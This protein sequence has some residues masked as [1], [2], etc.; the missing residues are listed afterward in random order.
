[1]ISADRARRRLVD[2]NDFLGFPPD[3]VAVVTG[4]GGGIGLAIT[5]LLDRVGIKVAAWD[6][7]TSGVLTELEE[8]ARLRGQAVVGFQ[9][10]V[11]DSAQVGDAFTATERRLGPIQFLVNNAGP[12]SKSAVDFDAG[13][14]AALG[15]VASV[16][17]AWL[18]TAGSRNGHV[19]NVSSVAG[20]WL[21]S[22]SSPWYAAAKAGIAGYT[23][24]LAVLRPNG[25]RANAI[26]PSVTVTQRTAPFIDGDAFQRALARNPMGR[27]GLPE[28]MATA[29]VFLLAPASS[30][31][32]GVLLPVDGGAVLVP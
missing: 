27:L 19:V 1:L 31:V 18:R 25:I 15:S 12:S 17:D 9:V 4:A 8:D 24:Q 2:C 11:T 5:R 32:N 16:T 20:N 22:A 21:G 30:Y 29:A 23:R 6:L 7:T 13:V 26:A 3:A 14:R 10:D 28:D